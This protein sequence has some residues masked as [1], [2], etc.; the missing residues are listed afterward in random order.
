ML[1]TG[2]TGHELQYSVYGDGHHCQ[3]PCRDSAILVCADPGRHVQIDGIGVP[4]I[5][6]AAQG[7]RTCDSTGAVAA[8]W[9]NRR[10][11][12]PFV[13]QCSPRTFVRDSAEPV[14]QSLARSPDRRRQGEIRFESD[15]PEGSGRPVG[16]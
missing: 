11:K 5:A 8:V 14:Q 16:H 4:I 1:K 12:R 15:R 6:S 7:V 10:E 2:I 13:R 3:A 9:E